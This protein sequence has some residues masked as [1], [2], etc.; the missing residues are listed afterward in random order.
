[1]I[2]YLLSDASGIVTGSVM[3]WDQNVIGALD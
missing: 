1:M 2:V 3:D